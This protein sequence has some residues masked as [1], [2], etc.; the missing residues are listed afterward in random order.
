MKTIFEEVG[1]EVTPQNKKD[2]DRVIHRIVGVAY[3]D[4]PSTWKAVKAHL[5]EDEEVFILE[6]KKGLGL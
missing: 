6:L 3:K 4:C 1:I 5:A 2:I